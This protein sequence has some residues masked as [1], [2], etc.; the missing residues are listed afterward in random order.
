MKFFFVFFFLIV[1]WG[2][3][4]RSTS[5]Q[6]EYSN[7]VPPPPLPANEQK[8]CDS[9]RALAYDGISNRALTIIFNDTITD[10][11]MY[12]RF[13]SILKN[14]LGFNYFRLDDMNNFQTL[15][16]KI[17]VQPIMDSAI[18]AEYGAIGKDSIINEA[19]RLTE[20]AYEKENEK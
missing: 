1:I 11:T 18:A 3:S 20:V 14:R 6:D 8:I 2:C 7:K 13:V 15:P 19:Y 9:L 10:V 17:C 4:T 5:P 12:K 16:H